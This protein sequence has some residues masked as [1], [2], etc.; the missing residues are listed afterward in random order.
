MS[1]IDPALW[2]W[3]ARLV[4]TGEGRVA[5][6]EV[7]EGP[8][9]L[10]VHGTPSW[11]I[12]WRH[13][14]RGLAD[15]RRCVMVDHLGFGRSERPEGAGYA[16]E[17]HARRLARVVDTLGL[18]RFD[19]AV[20]DFGGPIAL[21]LALAG[22]VDRLVVINTWMWPLDDDPALGW[23][24]RL[25]GTGFFR[26]LYRHL[27]LSL[28]VIAPSAWG[29][30]SK[31]TSAL[32]AQLEAPFA[33][34]PEAR[35]TVLWALAKALGGSSPFYADLWAR[36]AALADVPA[37]VLW[38]MRDSAFPPHLLDRWAE[39][40]PHARVVRLAEAGHWPHE[41]DPGAVVS[42]LRGFLA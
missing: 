5:V 21:P 37:L 29:D 15:R 32:Q 13:V 7:G 10:L 36:R 40:L 27:N 1:W 12:D 18:D 35:V 22:R 16:P 4:D 9:L 39:A 25:A 14:A 17:D 34:D 11:S 33:D 28:K 6:T 38:G 26:C 24:A 41:E 31:L 20:H 3:D 8:P 23:K 2:P 42:E 19:L 30:R